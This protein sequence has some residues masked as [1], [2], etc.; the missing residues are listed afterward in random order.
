[1]SVADQKSSQEAGPT[2]QVAVITGAGSGIG[3][4]C[5]LK[6]VDAGMAIVGVGR[7]PGKLRDLE[8]AIG[9]PDRVAT[10]AADITEDD[11][12]KRIVDLAVRRWGRID[13]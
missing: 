7:D 2:R 13:V 11:A 6:L 1:M 3:L 4:G 10:L 5:A 9:D 12:P 8:S